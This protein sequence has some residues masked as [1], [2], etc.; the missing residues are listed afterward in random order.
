MTDINGVLNGYITLAAM[1]VKSG[2]QCN[3]VSFLRSDWC[4]YLCSTVSMYLQDKCADKQ[5][6]LYIGNE[7]RKYKS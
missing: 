3:D 7:L 2:R 4:D 1:I 6:A 5:H